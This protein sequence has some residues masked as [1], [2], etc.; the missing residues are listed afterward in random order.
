[1][2]SAVTGLILAGGAAQ[3]MGRPKALLEVNGET[4]LARIARAL[5][6]GGCQNIIVV[7]GAQHR[8]VAAQAPAHLTLIR[9]PCWYQGMRTSLRAGLRCIQ[10]GSIVITHVDRP[11]ISPRTVHTLVHEQGNRPLVPTFKGQTG[12]PVIIPHWVAMKLRA[13]GNEP[14]REMLARC[15]FKR[16]PVSD[17]G[18]LLN[19]NTPSNHDIFVSRAHKYRSRACIEARSV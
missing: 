6:A 4:Y 3:R 10:E 1:M 17:E 7:T 11:A 16:M 13:P 12:H 14:L 5:L 15:Q 18:I 19:V 8:A 9:E 2:T